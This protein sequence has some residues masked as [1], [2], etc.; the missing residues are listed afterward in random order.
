LAPR[1]LHPFRSPAK[2]RGDPGQTETYTAT[3]PAISL[4]PISCEGGNCGAR[5]RADWLDGHP[6]VV[7]PGCEPGVG[8]R[9]GVALAIELAISKGHGTVAEPAVIRRSPR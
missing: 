1:E 7:P 4:A 9:S 2:P 6:L 5:D 3:R 8:D